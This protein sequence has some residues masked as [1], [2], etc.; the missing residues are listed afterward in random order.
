MISTVHLAIFTIILGLT[1]I[2]RTFTNRL[3]II[4]N[5]RDLAFQILEKNS[6]KHSSRPHLVFAGELDV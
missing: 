4:L 5:D 3:L 6:I 2:L 1:V